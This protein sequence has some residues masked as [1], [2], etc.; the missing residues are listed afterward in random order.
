[1]PVTGSSELQQPRRVGR[2]GRSGAATITVSPE[3]AVLRV[4]PD[5]SSTPICGR[6]RRW[7]AGNLAPEA[8]D[9]TAIASAPSPIRLGAVALARELHPGLVVLR[10]ALSATDQQT[11]VDIAIRLGGD[12]RGSCRSGG[13]YRATR[14]GGVELNTAAERR[15][16]FVLPLS[17]CPPELA[18]TCARHFSAAK[19]ASRS[20]PGLEAQ[21]CA[22]NFY[23][24]DSPGLRWH[25][26]ADETG[27]N[28]R[29]GRGRP[30]VSLSLG[31]DCTFEFRSPAADG[32]EQTGSL[33][34]SSGDVLVFGGPARGMLHAVTAVHARTAPSWLRMPRGRVNLTF[35]H[36]V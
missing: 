14:G 34:L 17:E 22:F 25:R 21:A 28:L 7:R 30:V 18:E 33:Q 27:T 31:D 2:W 13:F 15:G 24:E 8:S 19:T 23:A 9:M 32:R 26:D 3:C 36:H 4:A 10:S 29:T 1:M 11:L 20:L 12:G 6:Q 35:R 5:I 16:S